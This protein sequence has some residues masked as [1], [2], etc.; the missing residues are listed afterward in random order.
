MASEIVIVSGLPRSG[1]SLMCQ[2][3][4]NGGIEVVTD[5]IRTADTDNPRGYFE[6]EKVKKIKD[7]PSWLPETRGKAFKMVSQLLYDLPRTERYRV[8][9]MQRDLEEMLISQEK[10][11]ERLGRPAAPRELMRKSFISHLARLHE[12]LDKQAHMAVLRVDYKS[13]VE[14]PAEMGEMINKFLDGR[15]DVSRMAASVDPSLYRNRVK[16]EPI[17]P[18][19]LPTQ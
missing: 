6:L 1:T 3:L 5:S 12:M 11:L 14:R 8:I 7:D 13:L 18:N 17:P 16:V 10:M 19:T 9:F 2:M 15:C 4:E